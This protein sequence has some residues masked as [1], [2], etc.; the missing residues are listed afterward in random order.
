MNGIQNYEWSMK[1]EYF[2]R[3]KLKEAEVKYLT[4]VKGVTPIRWAVF[5]VL[6]G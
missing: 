2:T 5:R 3:K 1:V 4:P 6:V